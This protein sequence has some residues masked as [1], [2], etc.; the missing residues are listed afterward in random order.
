MQ[1]INKFF[2]IF[3]VLI[4]S[5]S[6]FASTDPDCVNHLGGAFYGV[7]CFGGLSNDLKFD[8]IKLKKKIFSSIPNKNKNKIIFNEYILNQEKNQ[9]YCELQRQ[10]MNN[11]IQ[12]PKTVNLNPRYY[13]YDV[14]YYECKYNLI[15][16][17]NDF[18]KNIVSNINQN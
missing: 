1:H 9:K 8:N 15:K 10:S 3:S 6:C 18:L 11:W 14:A 7:E 13:D 17:E 5:G 16:Q 2:L 4:A 12:Q